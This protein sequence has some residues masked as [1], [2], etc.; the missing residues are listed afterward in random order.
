MKQRSKPSRL[1]SMLPTVHNMDSFGFDARVFGN[2]PDV[3]PSWA[4]LLDRRAKGR[5][6]LVDDP[7]IGFFGYSFEVLF[8]F[9]SETDHHGIF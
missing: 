5:I 2:G 6:A 1:I 3:R 8:C 9:Y 4:W 7:A